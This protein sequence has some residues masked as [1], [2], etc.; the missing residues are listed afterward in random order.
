[1]GLFGEGLVDKRVWVIKTHYPERYGKTKFY[2]ERCVLLVRSPLD[3]I[4]SLF[5]MVCSGT[6]DLSI[7]D[8]DFTRFPNHWAEFIQQEI[9]VWKD[10]H[11]FWLKAKIPVHVIRYE[12]VV[13]A[14]RPTLC[15]LFKFILNV[16]TLEG[17]RIEKYVEL[18]CKEKAPEVYKPRKGR[19][20][21]N[22]AK[23]KSEH[24]EYM[25]NY[26]KDLID[27][28]GYT[29][30]FQTRQSENASGVISTTAV[31]KSELVSP[32]GDNSNIRAYNATSREKSIYNMFES[33]E[34]TSVMINYP[35][36][37]LRKK[38][39]LYP[40]GRTSYRFKNAL[41]RQVTV[42][43]VSMFAP[44]KK[45]MKRPAVPNELDLPETDEP[46]TE[47]AAREQSATSEDPS[48]GLI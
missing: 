48:A 36:L 28:F 17:T 4:T 33:D 39:A 29:S 1:M 38:S 25:Y 47:K 21:N 8:A 19:V 11:D 46:A 12:D 30:L 15:E 23:F 16:N 3:C 24:L 35:A 5:N 44:K 14:P 22:V 20:N 27:R 41:R 2:A 13:L 31:A 34:V 9:S 37:L 40:E 26:A 43:G 42:H 45:K 32:I 7:E 18:A 6:H 10:F